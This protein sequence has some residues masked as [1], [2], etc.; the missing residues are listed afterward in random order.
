MTTTLTP[1]GLFADATRL[2]RVALRLDSV[3]T[4]A[5]GV[6]YLALAG[7]LEDLLGLNPGIARGIG[8]FLLVYAV[9]VWLVSVP[10][11]PGRMAVTAVVETNLLWTVLSIATVIFGW[12]SLT[13]VGATWAVFQ[14]V[15][16]AGF[17]VLQYTALRRTR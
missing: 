14:A 17:A 15:T 6:L 16:V 3:V 12:F 9:A 2:L 8:A 13:T 11:R 10:A 1:T 4:G 7:P 5:N